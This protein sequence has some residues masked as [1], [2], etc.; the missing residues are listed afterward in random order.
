MGGPLTG[1]GGEG[2]IPLTQK[3]SLITKNL[4]SSLKEEVQVAIS[5]KL[6]VTYFSHERANALMLL[7]KENKLL[8]A[9]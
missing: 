1:G 2:V 9:L 7:E 4:C 5:K 8:H 3:A 6:R